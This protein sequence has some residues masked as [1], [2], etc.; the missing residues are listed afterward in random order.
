MPLIIDEAEVSQIFNRMS[1]YVMSRILNLRLE[2][3]AL[4]WLYTSLCGVL[5][6]QKFS[7][8]IR[9]LRY[10][11]WSGSTCKND[12]RVRR[13]TVKEGNNLRNIDVSAVQMRANVVKN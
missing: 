3:N 6:L 11:L 7:N 10:C 5:Y 12:A 2:I 8:Q 9:S 4:A 13:L 1:E